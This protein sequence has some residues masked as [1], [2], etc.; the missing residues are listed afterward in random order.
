MMKLLL[1]LFVTIV[2][3]HQLVEAESK[4]ENPLYIVEEEEPIPPPVPKELV[5][6][7]YNEHSIP[8][9]SELEVPFSSDPSLATYYIDVGPHTDINTLPN[10]SC[11]DLPR[12]SKANPHKTNVTYVIS[13]LADQERDGSEMAPTPEIAR[14]AKLRDD[15][16]KS[17]IDAI[18]MRVQILGSLSSLAP[19]EQQELKQRKE[20]LKRIYAQKNVKES[21][22][23]KDAVESD[24]PLCASR[25]K[26]V[27]FQD[28][29]SGDY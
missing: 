17:E 11:G 29:G 7:E 28:G 19:W 14:D 5:E 6:T 2:S 13:P 12:C 23:V 21:E 27:N 16:T 25:K 1:L 10:Y 22:E 24:D 20:T 15:I 8:N 18:E 9:D 26:G 3:G 4:S